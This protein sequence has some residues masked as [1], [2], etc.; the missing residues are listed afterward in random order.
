MCALLLGPDSGA[1]PVLT[2]VEA[3]GVT[4]QYVTRAMVMGS[5]M[6]NRGLS[7]RWRRCMTV[8][9]ARGMMREVAGEITEEMGWT[10][11]EAAGW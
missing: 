7:R 11:G 3:N 4:E 1:Y 10:T 8:A 5:A 6:T 2:M 9:E